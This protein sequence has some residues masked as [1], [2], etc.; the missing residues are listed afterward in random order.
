MVSSR[1]TG[2]VAVLAVLLAVYLIPTTSA[3]ARVSAAAPNGISGGQS[4]GGTAG[5]ASV[6]TL[7]GVAAEAGHLS[8]RPLTVSCAA[9]TQQWAQELTNVGLPGAAAEYYGF[10]LI[11]Q[12]EMQLSPYVCQG[13]RLGS[14]ASTRRSHELK[15]AWSVDVL[16]H[17]SVHLGRFT[18]DE[19]LAEA[20]ARTGLE[21]ELH[22]LYQV[23]Y[24][25]AEM[26]RLTRAAALFRST[27]GPDYRG[28]TCSALAA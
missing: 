24:R 25:S 21:S 17:E 9:T 23:P 12:G 5:A 10:S 18:Y 14:V 22:R 6:R 8:G 4:V 13:L 3:Q 20:C 16:I 28:G 11:P 15:V 2:A 1:A 26:R 7:A 19:A 27:Q